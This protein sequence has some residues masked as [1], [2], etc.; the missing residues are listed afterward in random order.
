MLEVWHIT[1]AHHTQTAF[2]GAG[3]R[4]YGGRWNAKGVLVVYTA[5]HLSLAVL[6]MLAQD[7]P[8]RARYQAISAQIPDGVPIKRLTVQ[9]LPRDWRASSGVAALH[10][11]GHAWLAEG[12]NAVMEVPSAVLPT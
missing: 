7:Q 5:A 4:L 9:Q 2:D 11:L 10:V 8:L 3:A 12:K 1:T 6:E